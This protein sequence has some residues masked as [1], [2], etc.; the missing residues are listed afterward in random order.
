MLVQSQLRRHLFRLTIPIFIETLLI[1]LLGFIDILMLSQVSDKAV[2]SVGFVNMILITTSMI[3]MVGATG[4]SVV[5]SQYI[6]ANQRENY[7]VSV[8]AALC[9][10]TIIGLLTSLIFFFFSHTI[11][12]AMDIDPTLY[13]DSLI[14]AQITGSGAIFVCLNM[15]MAV[16]LRSSNFT[17]YPMYISFIINILNFL[18]NYALIFGNFGFP[19]LGVEGAAIST[20]FSRTVAC[21]LLFYVLRVKAVKLPLLPR[22]LK[23]PPIEL[24]DKLKKIL[25]IGLPS[26]GELLSYSLSQLCIMYFINQIGTEAVA[27][28]TYIVNFVMFTFVFAMAIGQG[29]SIAVGQL[30]GK[31]QEKAALLLGKF[32]IRLAIY[33][34]TSMSIILAV[35]S[36]YLMPIMT[37]NMAILA[38]CYK[39]FWIDI[40][41]EV[42]RAV[43]IL[44][45]R[46]LSAVGNPQYPFVIGIIFMWLFATLG[47]YVFGLILGFG[48]IGMWFAFIFDEV[49]RAILMW[50]R[51]NSEKW[52]NRGFVKKNKV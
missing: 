39:I 23:F 27:A 45:G 51:W 12:L 37:T 26:A 29:S 5:C 40:I 14:Y 21:V 7:T 15:A 34:S 13:N 17:L 38:I 22:I 3:F 49:S 4:A 28:R 20:F 42:A 30:I 46:L 25:F 9:F 31:N 6:G 1:M 2:A 52:K 47:S 41:L 35:L 36:P 10:N 44:A 43:N 48:L 8:A 33:V 32:S 19:A 50:L 11:L 24:W 16:I 18:G